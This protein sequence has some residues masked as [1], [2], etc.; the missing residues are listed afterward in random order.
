MPRGRFIMEAGV[1]LLAA[2]SLHS[3]HSWTQEGQSRSFSSRPHKGTFKS[4]NTAKP[5][6]L[7]NSW[8]NFY[9]LKAATVWTWWNKVSREAKLVFGGLFLE[10]LSHQLTFCV[11]LRVWM[12]SWWSPVSPEISWKYLWRRLCAQWR[13]QVCVNVFCY[14]NTLTGGFS[15]EMLCCYFGP[16]PWWQHCNSSLWAQ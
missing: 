4:S 11:Q 16:H 15:E 7:F 5:L 1:F 9:T 12:H 8:R 14:W 13:T 6:S 3:S 2:F 10:G